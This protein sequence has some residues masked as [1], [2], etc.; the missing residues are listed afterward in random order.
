MYGRYASFLPAD[1]L[2]RLLATVNPPPNLKPTWNMAPTMDAPVVRLDRDTNGRHLDVMKWGL[3]PY[4]TKD[5]KK[6]RKPITTA[7][8]QQLSVIQDRM[9]VITSGWTGRTARCR[10]RSPA[11]DDAECLQPDALSCLLLLASL[12]RF[13]R[14]LGHTDGA[15]GNGLIR[16]QWELAEPPGGGRRARDQHAS[17]RRDD[18]PSAGA[19]T[20]VDAEEKP[21]KRE[22]QAQPVGMPRWQ[23][24]ALGC[25]AAA[26]VVMFVVAPSR[27]ADDHTWV[28]GTV[29]API[30]SNGG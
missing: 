6:A 23:K 3:V 10:L 29:V 16:R 24:G 13:W 19:P 30:R 4:F 25:L 20:S 8:N 1:Y 14:V 2:A 21:G 18:D 26:A 12:P 17:R 22:G 28:V 15:E 9:P 5:L 27:L 11:F 7:A